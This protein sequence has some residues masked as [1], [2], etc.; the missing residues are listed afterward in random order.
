MPELQ[1]RSEPSLDRHCLEIERCNQRGGRMLTLI[2][3]VRAGTVDMP[4]AAYLLGMVASG[5]SFMIGCIPGGGGKTTVMGALLNVTPVDVELRAADSISLIRQGL[6][7]AGSRR[8]YICHEIG[9]GPYYAYLWDGAARAFFQLT[10]TP[11]IV[12]TNLHADTLEEARAQLCDENGVDPQDFER[13]SVK[14]FLHVGHR[15]E[16]RQRRISAV[17]ESK[18]GAGHRTIFQWDAEKDSF[19]RREASHLIPEACEARCFDALQV[20]MKQPVN[21][22]LRVVRQALLPLL[23]HLGR[24]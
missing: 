23:N 13:V 12:A 21:C 5:H 24:P 3:L 22:T 19:T 10:R 9:P 20:L 1:E 15:R 14:L 18:V 4:L 8:C 6:R 11:H 2:D 16:G 17:H 7:H